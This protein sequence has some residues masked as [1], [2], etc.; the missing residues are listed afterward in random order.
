MPCV[1]VTFA[2][3]SCKIIPISFDMLVHLFAHLSAG[4]NSYT[5]AERISVKCDEWNSH[6]YTST[7]FFRS[8][9][10]VSG[11]ISKIIF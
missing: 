11:R 3:V 7:Y 1:H 5:A 8:S 2:N 10:V 4:S 9:T 6:E